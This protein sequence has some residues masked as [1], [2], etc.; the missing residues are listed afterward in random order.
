[1]PLLYRVWYYHFFP[2]WEASAILYHSL[3]GTAQSVYLGTTVNKHLI[4]H[5]RKTGSNRTMFILFPGHL[6]YSPY[7]F[8][9]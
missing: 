7:G 4:T 6:K 8:L 9:P 2:Y 3:F 1:M 5:H